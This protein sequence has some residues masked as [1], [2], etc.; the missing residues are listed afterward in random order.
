MSDLVFPITAGRSVRSPH[1]FLPNV[2]ASSKAPLSVRHTSGSVD[3]RSE[4]TL[5]LTPGLRDEW[6]CLLSSVSHRSRRWTTCTPFASS[7]RKSPYFLLFFLVWM[8]HRRFASV[9][10]PVPQT[11][12][13]AGSNSLPSP[14]T[15]GFHSPSRLF[16]VFL[17]FYVLTGV[18]GLVLKPVGCARLSVG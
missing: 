5:G 8:W 12:R 17:L 11:L 18:A 2:R 14:P 3:R 13:S 4:T 10:E 9:I 16:S 7:F 15:G 1:H 6:A